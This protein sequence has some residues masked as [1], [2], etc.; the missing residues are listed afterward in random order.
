MNFVTGES[1]RVRPLATVSNK[2]NQ[3]SQMCSEG[4]RRNKARPL[5]GFKPG[6]GYTLIWTRVI[7]N[8]IDGGGWDVS[9]PLRWALTS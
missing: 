7:G 1:Y 2:S 5:E 4:L 3:P 6:E 8:C 9:D